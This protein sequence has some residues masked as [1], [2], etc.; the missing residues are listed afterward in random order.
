[1]IS[2]RIQKEIRQLANKKFRDAE[3][4]F[5][6]EGSKCVPELLGAFSCRTVVATPD[7]LLENSCLLPSGVDILEVSHD[8]LQRVSLQ[9]HPQEVLAIFRQPV[10]R[11]A[12]LAGKDDLILALDGVQDPGNLGTILRIADWYGIRHLVCSSD[13][14]DPYSPKVVQA[15]MGS[16][17]RVMVHREDL[18][19][20][21]RSQP[22]TVPIYGTT[23]Q[24]TNMHETRIH[25]H[26]IIVM[27][28]EGRGLSPTV[29]SCLTK[30]LFIPRYPLDN[31]NP[32][33]LNV[34]IATGIV[35]AFFRHGSVI[36]DSRFC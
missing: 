22:A 4:L 9:Q 26:G 16:L 20:W 27:G 15:T 21:L 5:L 11:P 17:A 8:E 1:M 31:G 10:V 12:P 28:N 13:C 36:L 23:L 18:P 29:R 19:S 3:G 6:A 35:C 7:W 14:A 30:E 24:G 33:S 2:K 34:A 25:R 32:E